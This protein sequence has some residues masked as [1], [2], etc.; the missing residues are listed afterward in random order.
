MVF[1]TFCTGTL[2]ELRRAWAAVDGYSHV[3]RFRSAADVRAALA[4]A[5][6]L[7]VRVEQ[8]SN[9]ITYPDVFAL[10]QE[11]RGLGASNRTAN[12][13]RTLTGKQRLLGMARRYQAQYPGAE[14]GIQASFEILAVAA[15]RP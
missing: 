1:S 3:N 11:L 6:L 10:M 8:D 7:A 13:C 9:V 2:C 4:E 12:R 5:G 14:G 15:T